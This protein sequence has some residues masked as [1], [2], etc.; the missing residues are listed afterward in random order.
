MFHFTLVHVP[1][2]HH[3]PDGLSRWRLQSGDKEEQEDDF[4]NWVD[5]GNRF[6][7]FVNV[8]PSQCLA[9]MA[10]QETLTLLWLSLGVFDCL[11]S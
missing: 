3:G 5:Q 9:I 4:D 1:G 11:C 8:L 2:T 6:M 7:H 10:H